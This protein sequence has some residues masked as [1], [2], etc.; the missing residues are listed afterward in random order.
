MCEELSLEPSSAVG[1]QKQNSFHILAV[2]NNAG[3]NVSVK[4]VFWFS[5]RKYSLVNLLDRKV[6]LF[7]IF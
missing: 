4:L 6:V 1:I 3:I 2:V 7:L 5:L